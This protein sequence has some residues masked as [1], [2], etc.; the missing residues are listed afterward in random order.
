MVAYGTALIG[1]YLVL[2]PFGLR[3]SRY[4]MHD[5][6]LFG[7]EESHLQE[8]ALGAHRVQRRVL[9]GVVHCQDLFSVSSLLIVV[10]LET[11]HQWKVEFCLI[12]RLAVTEFDS[13]LVKLLF[14]LWSEAK[15]GLLKSSLV[16]LDLLAAD[17]LLGQV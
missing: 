3:L 4:L 10:S 11:M 2:R 9:D 16:F 6:T 8:V 15:E 5:V 1:P 12:W 13:S 17:E 7:P 14:K